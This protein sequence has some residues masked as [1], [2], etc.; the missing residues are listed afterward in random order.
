MADLSHKTV[1]VL[2]VSIEGAI[3]APIAAAAMNACKAG[4]FR[5]FSAG[6]RPAAAIP[7]ATL[8]ALRIA[9][10]PSAGIQAAP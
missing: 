7:S 3:R 8:D 9:S 1:T 4:G 6:I 5:A 10:I 2:F